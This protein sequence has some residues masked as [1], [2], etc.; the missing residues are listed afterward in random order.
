MDPSRYIKSFKTK[1]ALEAERK[2]LK[3][4]KHQIGAK[5]ITKKKFTNKLGK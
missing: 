2:K 1:I 4:S 3:K 5:A